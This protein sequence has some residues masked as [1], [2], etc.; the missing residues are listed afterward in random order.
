MQLTTFKYPPQ[1]FVVLHS[2]LELNRAVVVFYSVEKSIEVV[3]VVV[4]QIFTIVAKIAL[5]L[6]ELMGDYFVVRRVEIEELK[7]LC[8]SWLDLD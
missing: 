1:T 8:F 4:D 7:R 5:G 6:D 3:F 2:C